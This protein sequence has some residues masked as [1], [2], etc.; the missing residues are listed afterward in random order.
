MQFISYK[1]QSMQILSA[2]HKNIKR[3]DA[4]CKKCIAI[5][6]SESLCTLLNSFKG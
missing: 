4:I 3:A 5:C 2:Y 6:E 1:G